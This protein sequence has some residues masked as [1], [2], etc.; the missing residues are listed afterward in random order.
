MTDET[1][2][3]T[4]KLGPFGLWPFVHIDEE[5]GQLF[6]IE[7]L[8]RSTMYELAQVTGFRTEVRGLR[9]RI[10][11]HVY[12][13]GRRDHTLYARGINTRKVEEL[14]AALKGYRAATPGI[15]AELERLSA[16]F[17]RSVLTP[18]EFERAKAIALRE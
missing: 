17:D 6:V 5:K 14:N 2:K 13:D 18:D 16:L 7:S 1:K 3:R 4:F 15:A 9:R 10:A 8:T 12:V 11:L